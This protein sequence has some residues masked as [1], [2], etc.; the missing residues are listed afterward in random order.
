MNLIRSAKERVKLL[1]FKKL[2]FTRRA[3]ENVQILD[4]DFLVLRGSAY[5]TPQEDSAWLVELSRRSNQI[6]DV[7]VNTG[8]STLLILAA[9][10]DA[11]LVL[12]EPDPVS[13]SVATENLIKNRLIKNVRIFPGFAS[14]SSGEEITFWSFFGDAAGSRFSEQAN[15]AKR[16]N[17]YSTVTSIALDDIVNQLGIMPDLVKMD[18]EGAEYEALQGAHSILG[19]GTTKFLIE[20]HAFNEDLLRSGSSKLLDILQP[21]DYEVWDLDTKDQ[22]TYDSPV[23]DRVRYHVLL[24]P[25]TM[26]F[27]EFLKNINAFD[28]Y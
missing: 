21:Y 24:T 10:K 12:V 28:A 25:K 3:T 17:Q 23:R 4:Q 2:G 1:L 13:L 7:G 20:M 27:P 18:I 6:F 8:Q 5:K 15:T 9:N 16:N 19:S 14:Q 26:G 11:N 22:V